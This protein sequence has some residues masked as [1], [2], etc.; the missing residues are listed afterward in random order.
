LSD[1]KA[2]FLQ[3]FILWAPTWRRTIAATSFSAPI[4]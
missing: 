2:L 4:F 1:D 3:G